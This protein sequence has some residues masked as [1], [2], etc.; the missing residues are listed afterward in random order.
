MHW[1]LRQ[2]LAR[3]YWEQAGDG[4]DGGTGGGGGTGG[5]DAAAAAKVIA[6]AAAAATAA[7]K[8]VDDAAALAAG[9]PKPTDAEAALLKEVM[10]K[11]TAIADLN[12]QLAQVNAKLA[13]FDGVDAD[14]A[15]ALKKEAADR[16]TAALEEKGQWDALKKQLVDQN[17]VALT[18]EQAKAKALADKGAALEA[19]IAELTV[20]NA[21]GTSTYIANEIDWSISKIRKLFGAHVEFD[22]KHVVVYD[23]PAGEA[24]RVALVDAKGDSLS[25][26]EGIKR[27]IE[28]DPDKDQMLKSKLKTGGNS[29]TLKGK[30]PVQDANVTGKSRIAAAL[31]KKAAK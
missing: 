24:G 16:A 23:K 6:D 30:P 9:K 20:G 19:Q 18:A 13:G 26:D 3:G 11:K 22:G 29:T 12:A 25:F 1:K 14:E 8:V 2:L 15:K 28:S 7:Q 31:S 27:L 10:T 5:D 17:N 4:T 21:F